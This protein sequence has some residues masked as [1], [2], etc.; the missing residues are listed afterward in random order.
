MLE[1]PRLLAARVSP[2][3]SSSSRFIPVFALT[4]RKASCFTVGITKTFAVLAATILALTSC[5]RSAPSFSRE[6]STTNPPSGDARAPSVVQTVTRRALSHRANH[7]CGAMLMLLARAVGARIGSEF[8][9]PLNEGDLLFMPVTDPSVSLGKTPRSPASERRAD[10]RAGGAI[11]GCKGG[12][13]DT[14]TDPSPLNM[15]ETIVHL[16]PREQGG[17]GSRWIFFARTEMGRAA[18]LPA[19]RTLDDR[20]SIASTC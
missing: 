12:R 16:K 3:R 15:T 6:S 10:A 13:A 18:E 4:G 8:M 5:L 19:S 9:P 20:L 7:A 2:W 17:R 14:S 11:R 1:S